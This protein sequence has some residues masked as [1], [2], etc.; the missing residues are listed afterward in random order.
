MLHAPRPPPALLR[1]T[2]FELPSELSLSAPSSS[3]DLDCRR[4]EG[5]RN[6]SSA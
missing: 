6:R 2:R 4:H 3:I 1:S 5:Q